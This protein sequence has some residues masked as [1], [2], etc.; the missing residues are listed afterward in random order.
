MAIEQYLDGVTDVVRAWP[1]A[2]ATDSVAAK[3]AISTSRFVMMAAS[4]A[5]LSIEDGGDHLIGLTKLVVEPA[6]ATACFT[7]IRSML[8]SC[9]IGAWLVDP[10]IDQT[11]RQARVFAFRRS[12]MIECRK[13]ASCNANTV[14]EVEFGKKII[15]LEQEATAEG[16]SLSVPPDSKSG[17][18]IKMPGATEM[19][20][21]VLGLDENYRLLSGIAHGHQWARQIMYKQTGP[22]QVAGTQGVLLTKTLSTVSFMLII[23]SGF[24]ALTKLLWNRSCFWGINTD[25]LEELVETAADRLQI[26]VHN[27]FWRSTATV[28]S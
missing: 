16:F 17:I 1:A 5:A 22:A 8:E 27:R 10:N 12:G 23:Q 24:L 25:Q 3:E 19:I 7:C 14:M 28:E 4:H 11:K 15:L 2:P 26:K 21:D 13:F 20:R 18:G 6:T 9:A